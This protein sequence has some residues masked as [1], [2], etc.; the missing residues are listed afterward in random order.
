MYRINDDKKLKTS[1]IKQIVL[2]SEHNINDRTF[3]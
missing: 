2:V 3:Y 1:N